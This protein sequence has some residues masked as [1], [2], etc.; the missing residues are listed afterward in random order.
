MLTFDFLYE[1]GTP[2]LDELF[3]S[4]CKPPLV[5]KFDVI[6]TECVDFV[7]LILHLGEV[8]A[9]IVAYFRKCEI[10]ELSLFSSVVNNKL[11]FHH[12]HCDL[13]EG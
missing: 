10:F 5:G 2:G 12:C 1:V 4:E 7:A 3:K 6:L 8:C 11:R 9:D 13:E